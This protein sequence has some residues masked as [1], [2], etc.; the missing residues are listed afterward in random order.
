MTP[1]VDLSPRHERCS[2]GKHINVVL[3]A[4]LVILLQMTGAYKDLWKLSYWTTV[5]RHFFG[6]V[7]WT[8]SD[9]TSSSSVAD[10][11][12]F[13]DG[14][15]EPDATSVQRSCF[16]ATPPFRPH[17]VLSLVMLR[18]EVFLE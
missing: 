16:P 2:F 18:T 9:T 3:V 5:L 12:V 7:L 8:Q 15:D 4:F 13:K 1:P 10:R 14:R 6:R 17:A 11:K